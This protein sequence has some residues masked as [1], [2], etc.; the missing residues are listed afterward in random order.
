MVMN[1]ASVTLSVPEQL[2]AI[3][4]IESLFAAR[5][6]CLDLKEWDRYGDLHTED[7]VSAAHQV[8]TGKITIR[9]R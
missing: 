6:R 2:L 4:E 9:N 7:V 5:L 8:G 1:P 3:E